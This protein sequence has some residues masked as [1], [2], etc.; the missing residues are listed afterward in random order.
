MIDRA[1]NQEMQISRITALFLAWRLF[2]WHFL[3]I[4]S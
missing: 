4:L 2:I 1:V 3:Q